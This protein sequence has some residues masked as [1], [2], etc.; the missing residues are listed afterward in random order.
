MTAKKSDIDPKVMEL[1]D[2]FGVMRYKAKL[3]EREAG[4]SKNKGG[5]PITRIIKLDATLEE[6]ARE[7]FANAKRPDPSIRVRNE[8]E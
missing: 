3:R 1:F 2:S 6:A 7:M 5:R 8:P 4:K